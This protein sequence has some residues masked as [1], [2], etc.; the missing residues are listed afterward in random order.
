MDALPYID[1]LTPD[2][3]KQVDALIEEELKRS[4]KRPADYLKEFPPV[5][6]PKFEGHPLLADEYERCAVLR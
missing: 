4:T 1:G 5:P 3:K 2:V 6:G